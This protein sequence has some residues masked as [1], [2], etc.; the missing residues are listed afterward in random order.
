M[1]AGQSLEQAY[2][3]LLRWYP[4]G[5]RARHADEMLGVLMAGAGPGQRR[6]GLA[7]AASLIGGAV[8]IRF[9]AATTGSAG[10]WRE[11]LGRAG[12]VL[13]LAWVV[14]MLTLD[15]PGIAGDLSAGLL[16]PSVLMMYGQEY[17]PPVVVVITVLA[18]WRR[19]ALAAIAAT[20]ILDTGNLGLRFLADFRPYDAVYL[21]VLGITALAL[22]AAP[23]R[24]RLMWKH[25]L[26]AV[27]VA[28]TAGVAELR[29]EVLQDGPRYSPPHLGPPGWPAAELAGLGVVAA[30]TVLLLARSAASRRLLVVVAVPLYFYVA[31][32][33]TPVFGVPSPLIYLPFAVLAGAAVLLA[34]RWARA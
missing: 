34:A 27:A 26:L 8:R 18:G 28:V 11:A 2:G 9:R 24:A 19:V 4:A 16:N 17:L 29:L 21:A 6:P 31:F 23:A 14:L 5:H 32:V 1:S 25:C 15:G 10:Q 7:D 33:V 20:A 22:V 13:P 12:V 3:R 30:V